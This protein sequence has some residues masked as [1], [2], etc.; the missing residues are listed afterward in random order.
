MMQ[1]QIDAFSQNPF[2][3]PQNVF[4]IS[5]ILKVDDVF[6]LDN[7]LMNLIINHLRPIESVASAKHVIIIY[8]VL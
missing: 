3:L 6:G 5:F 1:Y 2:F 8:H 7:L 4:I